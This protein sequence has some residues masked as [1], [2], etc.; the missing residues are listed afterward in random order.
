MDYAAQAPG[1]TAD[2]AT[3]GATAVAA[4]P[5]TTPTAGATAAAALEVSN[6]LSNRANFGAVKVYRCEAV[7]SGKIYPRIGTSQAGAVQRAPAR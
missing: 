7:G 2:Q 5:S 4:L 1:T 6:A 3:A